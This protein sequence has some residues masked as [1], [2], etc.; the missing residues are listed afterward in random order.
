MVDFIK[1]IL[2]GN[3]RDSISTDKLRLNIWMVESQK[4]NDLIFLPRVPR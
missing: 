1:V 2:P 3:Q 4:I